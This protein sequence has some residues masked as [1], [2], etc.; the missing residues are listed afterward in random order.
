MSEKE[1][2]IEGATA[3]GKP[4]TDAEI[5][6]AIKVLRRINYRLRHSEPETIDGKMTGI[7]YVGQGIMN[8]EECLVMRTTDP[9]IFN[10][11][12]NKMEKV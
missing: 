11:E 4:L 6:F 3:K 7:Y 8:L 9:L 2:P 1:I 12:L 5:A 10:H